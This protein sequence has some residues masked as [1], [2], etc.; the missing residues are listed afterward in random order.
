MAQLEKVLAPLR[1]VW[2]NA[3]TNAWIEAPHRCFPFNR[4]VARYK[5]NG[6][7]LMSLQHALKEDLN[8]LFTVKWK[9]PKGYRH[10]AKTPVLL[11]KVPITEEQLDLNL[12]ELE[13]Q[14]NPASS[15]EASFELDLAKQAQEEFNGAEFS[16]EYQEWYRENVQVQHADLED[17]IDADQHLLLWQQQKENN[18]ANA[19]QKVEA[20]RVKR[21]ADRKAVLLGELEDNDSLLTTLTKRRESLQKRIAKLRLEGYSLEG[22]LRTVLA[23]E[24]GTPRGQTYF[25]YKKRVNKAERVAVIKAMLAKEAVDAAYLADSESLGAFEDTCERTAM[26]QL[27]DATC[28]YSKDEAK[29]FAEDNGDK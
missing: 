5:D 1:K 15:N 3:P 11:L 18:A 14:E 22:K 19:A 27:E 25:G 4:Y 6:C 20:E 29:W 9:H 13:R 7:E 8:E 2:E 17:S 21:I 28:E 12:Q 26:Q 16:P 24:S 23:R 10:G